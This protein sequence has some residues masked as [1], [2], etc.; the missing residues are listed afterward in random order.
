ML[1]DQWSV[2]SLPLAVTGVPAVN[3]RSTADRRPGSLFRAT[4]DLE[5][6]PAD[7]F[8]D[9]SKH[10]K[11]MLW[12]NGHN[13]GRY[14]SVG[15]QLRLYCPASWLKREGNVLEIIDLE[16][17]TPRPLRGCRERNYDVNDA[18]TRNANNEW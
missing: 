18:S 14:W 4:F 9:M 13:L 1:L 16:L 15:P 12:V 7:T 5:C 8:F 3:K 11:G 2:S 10:E 6:C 17:A